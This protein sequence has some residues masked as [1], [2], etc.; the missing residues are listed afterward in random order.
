MPHQIIQS[1]IDSHGLAAQTHRAGYEEGVKIGRREMRIEFSGMVGEM[2]SVLAHLAP[3]PDD[4][5]FDD[6]YDVESLIDRAKKLLDETAAD[7]ED[8]Q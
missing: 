5:C 1:I 7:G 6:R 3:G 4:D 2:C 8:A